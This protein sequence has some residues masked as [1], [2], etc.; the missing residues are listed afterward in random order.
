MSNA[1]AIDLKRAVGAG[2]A[3]AG[4]VRKTSSTT[5]A[6]A[7]IM[8]IVHRWAGLPKMASVLRG[9]KNGELTAIVIDTG[10][11]TRNM[12]S[13]RTYRPMSASLVN[14]DAVPFP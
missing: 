7:D 6:R 8:D 5:F 1:I 9:R 4:S 14:A 2:S 3:R 10:E 13:L 11:N 12:K